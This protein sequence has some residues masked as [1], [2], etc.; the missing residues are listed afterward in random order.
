MAAHRSLQRAEVVNDGWKDK[1]ER[2]QKDDQVEIGHL[3]MDIRKKNAEIA[4][5]KL[6]GDVETLKEDVNRLEANNSRLE[7][8]NSILCPDIA[9]RASS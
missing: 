3:K 5:S 4:N 9:R 6:E 8:D 1:L 2:E 7:A